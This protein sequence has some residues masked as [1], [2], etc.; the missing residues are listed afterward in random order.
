MNW[1]LAKFVYQVVSG[2]G[3]HAAQFDEQLR[4]IRADEFEWACE[5]ASILGR[6]G[7]CNFF[8]D[9]QEEVK[10]KFINVVDVCPITSIEDGA[11]VYASIE[12]PKDVADYLARIHSK[13]FMLTQGKTLHLA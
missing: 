5:K 13:A 1:Y 9:R 4:L 3:S 12:E 10:W 8:N 2:N 7:E 11:E 6:L